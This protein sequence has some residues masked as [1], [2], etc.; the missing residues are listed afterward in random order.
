MGGEHRTSVGS[1]C[2]LVSSLGWVVHMAR[3]SVLAYCTWIFGTSLRQY[4][5]LPRLREFTSTFDSR[6]LCDRSR[7]SSLNPAR[8]LRP[9]PSVR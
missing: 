7:S 4:C 1:L 6:V 9:G 3:R 2:G 5:L 8:T